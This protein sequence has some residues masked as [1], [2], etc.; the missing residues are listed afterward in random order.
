MRSRGAFTLLELVVAITIVA[1]LAVLGY[2]G[3]KLARDRG[4]AAK[5]VSNLRQLAT[6][7]LTYVAEN[8]GEF[9]AAQEPENLI[10][11]HGQRASVYSRFDPTQG[12]L[13]PYLG[14]SRRIQLCPALGRVLEGEWS[15]EEGT[16]GYGYNATY[17]GGTPGYPFKPERLINIP[18]P[19]RVMMF[20]DCAFPRENGIQEYPYAEPWQWIDYRGRTRGGLSPSVH[21]RHNDLA[22]VAWADGH[23]TT[24]EPT[25]FGEHNYYGG[26]AR[27]WKVGWFGPSEENGHWNPNRQTH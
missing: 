6:A 26:D 8:G 12:P 23:I 1:V 17:I 3:A 24:E 22:N 25:R 16:G 4:D 11:W 9:P 27:K 15:F 5:C 19:N 10:R 7:T 13:A 21:F 2:A 18:A 14:F 20:S